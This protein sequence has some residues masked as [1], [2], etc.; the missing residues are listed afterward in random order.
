MVSC[1]FIERWRKVQCVFWAGNKAN[2]NTIKIF[3]FRFGSACFLTQAFLVPACV[4]F[5]YA[6]WNFLELH[7]FLKLYHSFLHVY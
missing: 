1:R 7:R 3:D 5:V 4:F 6:P 2:D